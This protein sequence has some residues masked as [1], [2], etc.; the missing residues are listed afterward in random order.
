[1]RLAGKMAVVVG[2]GGGMGQ[3]TALLFGREGARVVAADADPETACATADQILVDHG[4]ACAVGADITRSAEVQD[5]VRRTAEQFGPPTILVNCAGVDT[6]EKKSLLD[7]AEPAFDRAVAVNLKGAWLLI[8]H[9]APEM[10]AAGGGSIVQVASRSAINTGLTIGY[11]GAKAGLISLVRVAAAELAE[12]KI[13]VN[14]LCPSA[15][16]TPLALK[17]RAE[18]A[19]KGVVFDDSMV[20]RMSL[21]GRM[22]D[23]AEVAK[24]ALF[25][26]SDEAS[27]LTGATYMHDSGWTAAR[28]FNGAVLPA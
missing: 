7:I 12:H 3:A 10:I 23:P 26:S 4:Q 21:L 2:A 28:S 5:I 27:Y 24:L 8:K 20:K 25:L 19:A 9:L 16:L 15:T 6:E 1:M 17:I 13:R 22:A 11:S 14:T 18:Q